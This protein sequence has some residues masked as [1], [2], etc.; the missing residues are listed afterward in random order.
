M[1]YKTFTL[2]N[3]VIIL[4]ILGL[5]VGVTLAALYV[6][7]QDDSKNIVMVPTEEAA[8]PISITDEFFIT[9][10]PAPLSTLYSVNLQNKT[11]VPVMVKGEEHQDF[12][13][14]DAIILEKNSHYYLLAEKGRPYFY[15][16]NLYK[17]DENGTLTKL[18]DTQT[19]KYGLSY[20]KESGVV[21][22]QSKPVT[23]TVDLLRNPEWDIEVY[24]PVSKKSS[25]VGKGTRAYVLAGGS[26]LL[27]QD[28][29][30]L[31]ILELSTSLPRQ[32]LAPDTNS[33]TTAE[34]STVSVIR[35]VKL[36]DLYANSKLAVDITNSNIAL[37]N[38][39]TRAMDMFS[40]AD[41][42][43][44]YTKSIEAVDQPQALSF[45]AGELF[46][47]NR[48]GIGDMSSILLKKLSE[49]DAVI[50]PVPTEVETLESVIRV[51]ASSL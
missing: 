28:S 6:M 22:Y 12:Q 43:V 15:V 35:T 26:R 46:V 40:F 11:I 25:V 10:G 45:V 1:F 32:Q 37:F 5:V 34:E 3:L 4:L 36:M 42:S 2:K 23:E 7:Q 19:Y 21:A 20:D 16:I 9:L 17:Q 50:I 29:V 24:N 14:L 27:V 33:T 8:P 41:G 31:S 30:S 39:R 49:T 38:P 44:S 13:V 47:A 51:T 48:A 18:T